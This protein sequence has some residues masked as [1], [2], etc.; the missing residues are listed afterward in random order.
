MKKKILSK[1]HAKAHK[2]FDPSMKN[3][4]FHDIA[5]TKLA[6]ASGILFLLTVWPSFSAVMLRIPWG[7]YF[8]VM[9]VFAIRPV[10]HFFKYCKKK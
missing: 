2:Q 4:D 6:V 7:W 5:F 8:I 3:L 9:I 1:L 10:M